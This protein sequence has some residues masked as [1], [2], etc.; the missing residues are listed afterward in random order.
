MAPHD[1]LLRKS[2]LLSSRLMTKR[3]VIEVKRVW[4]EERE[5][6]KGLRKIRLEGMRLSRQA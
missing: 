3:K 2:G 1:T 6:I 4:R 5:G